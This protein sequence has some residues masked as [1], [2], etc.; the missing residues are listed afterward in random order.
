[1]NMASIVKEMKRLLA[2]FSYATQ[3]LLHVI[4]KERNMQIHLTIACIVLFFAY[5]FSVS[6][7]EWIVILLCIGIMLSLESLN[8][9]IE[10]TVDL[11]TEEIKP[12]AKQAKDVAAGAV[13]VFAII[14]VIIGL[15]IFLKPLLIFLNFV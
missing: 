10:R 15:I 8:T 12:L 14:S 4:K 3:G 5:F 9:A 6:K 7:L 13:F 1:M 11:C 2:S